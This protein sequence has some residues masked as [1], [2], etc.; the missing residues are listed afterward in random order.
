MNQPVICVG[1]VHG[2][3]LT[4]QALLAKHPNRRVILLGDLIDRGPRS[5]EVVEWT[6]N[7][8]IECVAANHEDLCLAYSRHHRMG[9]R[10]K[11]ASMYDRD[12][13]LW[14]GGDKALDSWEA[15]LLP[16]SVLPR[17]VLD[18]MSKLPPYIIIDQESQGRKLLVSH[19]GYGLEADKGHWELALWGRHP[20][21]GEFAY[22]EG[23]GKPDDD[24]WFRAFG[25]NREKEVRMT[26]SYAMFDT[27]CAYEG[28]G[29]LSA[30]LWPEREIVQHENIDD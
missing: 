19:T 18:W 9:Y 15:D 6:M 17:K 24:G 2:C 22:E 12:V 13:W 3:W 28:F 1:D 26:D 10:A 29:V 14:N 30:M 21:D 27:G 8:N 20:D 7:N 11:C 16:E 5:R 25:H 23:T 4:L